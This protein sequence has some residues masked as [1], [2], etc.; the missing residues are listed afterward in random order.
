MNELNDLRTQGLPHE[1]DATRALDKASHCGFETL[2]CGKCGPQN[3][4]KSLRHKAKPHHFDFP[5]IYFTYYFLDLFF[6]ERF[7]P[8]RISI[9]KCLIGIIALYSI[10]RKMLW[11]VLLGRYDLLFKLLPL[12]YHD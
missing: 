4:C 1:H 10:S 8:K 3:S 12:L 6:L 7:E 11:L 2:V 9:M 5:P